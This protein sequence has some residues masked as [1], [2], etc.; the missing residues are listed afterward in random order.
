MSS[1]FSPR[2]DTESAAIRN[3]NAP[4]MSLVAQFDDFCRRVADDDDEVLSTI[5]EFVRNQ[6]AC[7]Q[8]WEAA[9]QCCSRLAEANESQALVNSELEAKL[10]YTR[11]VLEREVQRRLKCE[12]HLR[13]LQAQLHQ[14]RCCVFGQ[15]FQNR[16]RMVTVLKSVLSQ[17]N[18]ASTMD[19]DSAQSVLSP[20]GTSLSSGAHHSGEMASRDIGGEAHR[21]LL[22]S[23]PLPWRPAETGD[24]EPDH[25]KSI[26][27]K[28]PGT[29]RSKRAAAAAAEQSTPRLGPA[30]AKVHFELSDSQKTSVSNR[31]CET[32]GRGEVF[33][34][35]MTVVAGEPGYVA[36]ITSQMEGSVGSRSASR[37]RFPRS[38]SGPALLV[39]HS[40][41]KATDKGPSVVHSST[42]SLDKSVVEEESGFVS[43]LQR[44]GPLNRSTPVS[45]ASQQHTFVSRPAVN[46]ENCAGC[47]K[48]IRFYKASYRC[49]ACGVVCHPECESLVPLP[50]GL[51]ASPRGVRGAS[52]G[53]GV[54]ADYAP[55]EPPFVP[56]LVVHCIREV[57]R[58]CIHERGPLYGSAAPPEEVDA[59]LEQLL[60]GRDLPVLS[61]HSLPVVCGSLMKFLATLRETVITKSIWPVLAKAAVTG[62]EDKENRIW[63]FLD[64][65]RQLPAANRAVLSMLLVHLHGV[66][67][68]S[69]GGDGRSLDELAAVFAP[70]LVGCST[71]SPSVEEQERDRHLQDLI[72][73]CLLGVPDVYWKDNADAGGHEPPQQERPGTATEDRCVSRWKDV[74]RRLKQS[75]GVSYL[76]LGN[77]K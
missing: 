19:D 13:A 62:D 61:E 28:S 41:Q 48:R 50:C 60:S 21:M 77:K 23:V 15:S 59:L 58:R 30:P 68:T 63:K 9:E 34:T 39:Q 8:R 65:T 10:R 2:H 3:D 76:V 67:N 51:G 42:F 12:A 44:M 40:S 35:T 52:S 75:I 46:P 26:P 55:S 66:S 36:T 20:M 69:L 24:T 17:D 4:R 16:D 54:L 18:F 11:D 38:H 43:R 56:P 14:I 1:H 70:V 27:T 49:D 71:S 53:A 25:Y 22:D 32:G 72:M 5:V 57:E 37:Q 73:H 64:A 47:D 31:S 45:E 33:A 74:K 29:P 7:R 6:E